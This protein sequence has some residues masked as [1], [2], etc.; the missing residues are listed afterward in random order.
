M[1][2]PVVA[3]QAGQSHIGRGCGLRGTGLLG[4]RADAGRAGGTSSNKARRQSLETAEKG[5][6]RSAEKGG[7]KGKQGY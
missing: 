6:G 4:T 7:K 5:S 3:K 1:G 2:P